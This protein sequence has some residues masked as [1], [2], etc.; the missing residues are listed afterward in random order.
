MLEISNLLSEV[1]MK[2]YKNSELNR[3]YQTK[4]R[5][6]NKLKKD[7]EF[8]KK[9]LDWMIY[10]EKYRY[11]YNFTWLGFPIIKY[12][13]DIIALQEIIWTTKPDIVIE[14]GIAHGGSII[15]IAS[16]LNMIKKNAKVIGIDIEIR[17]HN[18]KLIKNS[19]FYKKNIELLQSSS[20]DPRLISKLKKI[21]KN[22]TVMV[23]L[24]SAHSH[25][26]VLS[27]LEVYSQL[28]TKNQYLVVEDTF[29]EFYPKNFFNYLT[30]SK[31]RQ[32]TNKGNNP[33]TA[34]REFLKKNKKFSTNNE[35]N[36]K[37]GITQNFDSY[38]LKKKN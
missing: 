29:E 37:L 17:K 3:F 9:S 2:N 5:M 31:V 24:D 4:L 6:I 27:E 30:T 26:H 28:V 36:K 35:F 22:K 1:I 23:I 7:D 25:D 18:L 16:L 20:T 14:T 32:E 12:P 21:C 8:K 38:L 13:N 10:A 33:M 15:F 11:V 34:M 19:I